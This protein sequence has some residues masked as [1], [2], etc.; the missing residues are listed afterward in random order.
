MFDEG[1]Y[2]LDNKKKRWYQSSLDTP[3][4]KAGDGIMC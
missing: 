4:K 2:E 1:Q 3:F